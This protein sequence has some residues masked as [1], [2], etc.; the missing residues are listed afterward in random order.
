[1]SG[2]GTAL[3]AEDL[4][5]WHEDRLHQLVHSIQDKYDPELRLYR[6]PFSSPGYHT[7]IKQ[8]EYVHG[9]NPNTIY[10]LALLDSGVHEYTQRACEVLESIVSL[11]DTDRSSATFGVWPWFY[12]EPLSEMAPPDWNW[13]DF[14]GKNLLLAL[15][16]HAEQLPGPL[17]GSMRQAVARAADAIVKRDVGPSYTNI[18]IMGAFVT[19]IGGELLE[20]ADYTAYGLQRLE[21]LRTYT[22]ALGAFQ[23]YNSPTYATITIVELSKLR[24][25]TKLEPVKELCD[26]MLDMAWK[27]VAEHF[28]ASTGEWAGPHSRSYG[29]LLKHEIKAFL[30]MATSGTVY[31]APWQQ[32]HYSAEWYRSGA[33]CPAKYAAHFRESAARTVYERFMKYEKTGIEKWAYCHIT[34]QFALGSFT[35]EIMWNQ[36]R[37]LVA[38]FTNNGA[39]TYMHVRFLN[40]GGD[41]SSALLHSLQ[42]EGHVLFGLNLFTNG[43]N[44]HPVLDPTNGTLVSSDLRIRF[45]FGG[46]MDGVEADLDD[47]RNVRVRISELTAAIHLAYS[48]FEEERNSD[49]AILHPPYW[50]IHREPGKLCV[51]YVLYAGQEKKFDLGSIQKAA[52]IFALSISQTGGPHMTVSVSEQPHGVIA[53]CRV[54]NHS[55][56]V[57]MHVK[58]CDV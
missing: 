46:V 17:R 13:A 26:D 25:E 6:T 15:K 8:A 24:L 16:R 7:R 39:A 32:M 20:R 12:E 58:P 45:E 29:T 14:I 44:A 3:S 56:S 10:A 47:G 4:N 22:T 51:D 55:L 19:V 33:T 30:Q 9:T 1:M 35:R 5:R 57:T 27:M 40:D 34:P 50:D 37:S 28:H 41:F 49:A 54:D 23:E 48:A 21:K 2:F 31:Y 11:Q 36:C 18:A 43:G 53:S 52:A 38:Y 42:S